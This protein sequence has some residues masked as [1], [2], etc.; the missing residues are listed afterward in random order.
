MN[1]IILIIAC[2]IKLLVIIIV[3][4]KNKD[5]F[6]SKSL[7]LIGVI[8]EIIFLILF[9]YILPLNQENNLINL[10]FYSNVVDIIYNL[11]FLLFPIGIFLYVKKE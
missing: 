9:N 2:L 6:L 11:S 1:T 10:F 7:M 3:F 8:S 4:R 5:L